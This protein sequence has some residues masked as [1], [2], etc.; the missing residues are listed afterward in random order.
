MLAGYRGGGRGTVQ[1]L[2]DPL[3]L[4]LPSSQGKTARGKEAELRTGL[5]RYLPVSGAIN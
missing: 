1:T 3:I 4:P 5:E 2:G